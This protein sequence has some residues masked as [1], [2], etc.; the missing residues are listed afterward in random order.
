MTDQNI[1][2]RRQ[3]VYALTGNASGQKC[4]ACRAC[5]Y[6]H[7]AD[8]LYGCDGMREYTQEEILSLIQKLKEKAN[9][10]V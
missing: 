8:A 5:G 3:I 10:S 6:F 7:C 2:E 9:V 4:D 1:M